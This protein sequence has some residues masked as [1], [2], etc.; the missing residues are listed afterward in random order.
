MDWKKFGLHTCIYFTVITTLLLLGWQLMNADVADTYGF[1]VI[2]I[3]CLLPFSAL[4]AFGNINFKYSASKLTW[5][6]LFHFLFT[7][8]GAFVFLYLP[9]REANSTLEAA[10]A[11]AVILIVIYW[12]VMGSFL[13]LRA[14]I[15]RI[16][17]DTKQ[18]KS[19]YRKNEDKKQATAKSGESK[20]N[21]D[22]YQ[23]VYKK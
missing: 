10:I 8:G 14:R 6:V 22:D 5:R 1:S 19:L 21:K 15:L 11:M 16:D 7:V 13:L 17:R 23:N 12:I 9:S 2:R 20:K 18:Y 3:L 4:F